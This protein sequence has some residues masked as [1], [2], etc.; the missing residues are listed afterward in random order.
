MPKIEFILPKAVV[1]DNA[2]IRR[3]IGIENSPQPATKFIPKEYKN[4]VNYLEKD[5]RNPTVKK[6]MPFL[7][8]MSSGYIIPFYQDNLISVDYEK[9]QWDVHTTFYQTKSLHSSNQLPENY[10]NGI[11]PI[12]KFSN[13]WIIKTQPGYSCLFVH[14][15]NTTKKDFEIISG[16]VDTDTFNDTI[17]FPYYFRR[18]DEGKGKTQVML[19]VGTPMVQVIPFKREK[20]KSKIMTGKDIGEIHSGGFANKFSGLMTDF[21]KRVHWKKKNYD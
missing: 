6:C 21:Y 5:L 15:M 12:A 3:G 19:K 1:F 20:W 2:E 18:H 14:P 17:L 7:D 16:I 4:V 11:K 10:Q 9:Q 13:K 8:A